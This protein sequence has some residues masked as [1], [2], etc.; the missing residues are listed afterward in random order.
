M[1]IHTHTHTHDDVHT[2]LLNLQLAKGSNA[3][4]TNYEKCLTR[5][6]ASKNIERTKS[7][8]FNVNRNN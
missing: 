2:L 6:W 8:Q 4:N 1:T 5:A 7:S 3:Q